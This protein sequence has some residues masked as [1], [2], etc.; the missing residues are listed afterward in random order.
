ML[1]AQALYQGLTDMQVKLDRL[2]AVQPEVGRITREMAPAIA[3]NHE[4]QATKAQ[5]LEVRDAQELVSPPSAHLN[6]TTEHVDLTTTIGPPSGSTSVFDRRGR[7]SKSEWQ[8]YAAPQD[9]GTYPAV[10]VGTVGALGPLEAGTQPSMLT[11]VCRQAPWSKVALA[12]PPCAVC[13]PAPS[14]P[15][16]TQSMDNDIDVGL[17]WRTSDGIRHPSAGFPPRDN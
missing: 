15:V 17:G 2:Q 4:L 1:N 11:G 12:S 9:E 14:S 7:K 5:L 6:S 16:T 3:L 10:S 13:M 8:A